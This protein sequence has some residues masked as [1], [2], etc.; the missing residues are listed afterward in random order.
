MFDRILNKQQKVVEENIEKL[1]HKF[2]TQI[3]N[4]YSEE[5]SHPELFGNKGPEG[6]ENRFESIKHYVMDCE[7]KNIVLEKQIDTLKGRIYKHDTMLTRV[8]R[9]ID[10]ELALKIKSIKEKRKADSVL[11]T[12]LREDKVKDDSEV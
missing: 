12:E 10:K 4:V 2:T 7:E 5:L 8:D 3:K 9:V 6:Q 1:D 11:I